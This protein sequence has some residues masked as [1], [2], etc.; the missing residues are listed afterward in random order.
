MTMGINTPLGL[1]YKMGVFDSTGTSLLAETSQASDSTAVG[2]NLTIS[3]TTNPTLTSGLTYKLRAYVNGNTAWCNADNTGFKDCTQDGT[4][5]TWPGT[6]TS[7]NQGGNG[8][9][10]IR[11]DGATGGGSVTEPWQQL[12]AMGVILAT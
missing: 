8:A 5:A 11:V 2:G 10:S 1:T 4:F 9:I 3:L 6:I 7:A 12:G